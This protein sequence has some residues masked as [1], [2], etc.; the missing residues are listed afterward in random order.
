MSGLLSLGWYPNVPVTVPSG[1]GGG[2]DWANENTL[3]FIEAL[4]SLGLICHFF[5]QLFILTNFK[6][7]KNHKNSTLK[8]YIR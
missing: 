7:E 1:S 6:S 4:A 8:T 5:F 3:S 2:N